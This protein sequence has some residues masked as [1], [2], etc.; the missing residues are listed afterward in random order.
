[1]AFHEVRFP[2]DIAYGSGGGPG[3]RTD[4]VEL[5]SGAEQRLSRWTDARRRFNV[6]YGVRSYSQLSS[7]LR[8]YIAR[9]GAENGFRYK[10]FLDFT[11]AID[12][13]SAHSATDV[14]IANGDGTT[15]TFQLKK[16][17]E[18][19]GVVR[20]R[21]ITK[22]VGGTSL[23]TVN[24][25][26]VDSADFSVSTTTG[27]VTFDTAP[28]NGHA[29]TWGGEFDVPVRFEREVDDLLRMSIDDFGSGSAL[30]VELIELI[31]DDETAEEFYYGGARVV[32]PMTTDVTLALN[33]GRAISLTPDSGGLRA[34][35]P[36]PASVQRG[37]PHFIVKNE[38]ETESLEIHYPNGTSLRTLEPGDG[39]F[40]NV[41]P[42]SSDVNV[43]M[44]A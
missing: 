31:D 17:Y 33:D 20:T 5:G 14:L 36:S 26:E 1:M 3:F 2:D 10:D 25:V 22:P 30:N 6:A 15:K 41:V 44:I 18:S 13:R 35:L 23:F 40:V 34:I 24:G 16:Y 27:L 42:N 32:N 11:T 28:P 8:F 39:V 7:L 29:I 38:S 12:N 4:V 21:N 19:G 43:W 37:G 9:K